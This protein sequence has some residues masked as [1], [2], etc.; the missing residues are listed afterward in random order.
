M[1]KPVAKINRRHFIG[2]VGAAAV[3]GAATLTVPAQA[4]PF[5]NFARRSLTF[6]NTH[7]NETVGGIYWANGY[8]DPRMLR[9]FCYIMRDH[10]AEEQTRIDP[11][12]FDVLHALQARLRN[13][14]HIQVISGYRSP[15]TNRWLAAQSSGVAKN[16]Y[17]MKG[18]A[19]DIRLAGEPT[20]YIYRAA[21]SLQAGGVGYY[22]SSDFV[23]VD[24]GPVRTWGRGVG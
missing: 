24:T 21:L 7:T 11:R 23:H 1:T 4:T 13:F 12:L 16:S 20:D 3:V 14:D 19:I 8:Y 10:R 15:T 18:Q 17:H 2:L 22:P 9:Q 5:Y 6:T